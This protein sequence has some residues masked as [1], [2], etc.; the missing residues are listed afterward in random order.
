MFS[1]LQLRVCLDRAAARPPLQLST[2]LAAAVPPSGVGSTPQEKQARG[3]VV[4][5]YNK[6]CELVLRVQRE[7]KI[8]HE[9]PKTPHNVRQAGERFRSTLEVG[10]FH[11]S[12]HMPRH[13]S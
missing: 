4:A 5:G 6:L 13:S 7:A 9:G 1:Q 2:A 3:Q 8:A 11:D 10:S 12:R